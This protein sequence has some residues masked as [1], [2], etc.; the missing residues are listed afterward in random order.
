MIRKISAILICLAIVFSFVA[1][2]KSWIASFAVLFEKSNIQR[3]IETTKQR[4][5]N[6]RKNHSLLMSIR[7]C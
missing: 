7:K 3:E 6:S 4:R 2:K 5:K 1:C